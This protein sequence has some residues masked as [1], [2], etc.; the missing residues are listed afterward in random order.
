MSDVANTLG[1]V[2][3]LNLKVVTNSP[4]FLS[5]N[6]ISTNEIQSFTMYFPY[7]TKITTIAKIKNL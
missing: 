1:R 5:A 7:T 4:K 6:Y 2:A 3:I